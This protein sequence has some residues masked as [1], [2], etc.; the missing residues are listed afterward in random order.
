LVVP[1]GSFDAVAACAADDFHAVSTGLVFDPVADGQGGEHDAQVL[2]WI[3]GVVLGGPG[4]RIVSAH[5][6][7]ILEA[8]RLSLN[9]V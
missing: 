2:R 1:L 7:T 8:P 6:K 4:L 3:R 9:G 5:P